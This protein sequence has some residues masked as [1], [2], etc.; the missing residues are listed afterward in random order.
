MLG[1]VVDLSD[2]AANPGFEGIETTD[3]LETAA[4]QFNAT[5]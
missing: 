3:S 2:I 5:I 4:Q 1:S